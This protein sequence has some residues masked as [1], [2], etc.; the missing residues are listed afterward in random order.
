MPRWRWL[1]RVINLAIS[2]RCGC[3]VAGRAASV[4]VA[5]NVVAVERAEDDAFATIGGSE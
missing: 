2:A 5:I 4:T 3:S 1:T